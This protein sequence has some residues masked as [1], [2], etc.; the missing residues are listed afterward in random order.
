MDGRVLWLYFGISVYALAVVFGLV[1]FIQSLGFLMNT[2]QTGGALFLLY[3]GCRML[4]DGI[5]AFRRATIESVNAS[6]HAMSEDDSLVV[7]LWQHALNGLLIVSFNPKVMIIFFAIFSH[8]LSADQS[9]STQ[10]FAAGMADGVDA[11]WYAI[12]EVLASNH[13][14]TLTLNRASP[15]VESAVG[16]LFVGIGLAVVLNLS[17][18]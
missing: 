14:P 11:A 12:V 18:R 10:L 15:L 16:A 13:R 9:L 7:G 1:A 5:R 8:I 2:L 3:L 6:D 17:K 4:L